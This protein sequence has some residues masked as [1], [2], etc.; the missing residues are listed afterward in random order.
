MKK[1]TKCLETKDATEFNKSKSHKGGL[2]YL[3]K[4]CHSEY[5]KQH[6]L[7]NKD[8]VIEQVK[9]YKLNNPDKYSDKNR[10]NKYSKRAGRINECKCSKCDNIVYQTNTELLSNKKTYCSKECRYKDNKSVYYLYLAEIKKRSIKSGKDF[11]LTEHFI[12]DLLENKQKN[13][14]KITSI[15]IRLFKEKEKKTLHGSASLD[16]IDSSRG[17]TEDN[18]QW[19]CLGIN[20]MKL[21]YSDEDLHLLLG[22][23]KEKYVGI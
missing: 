5:R 9:E 17:Y 13:K 14:C 1:C 21:N 16:R 3:C 19:V 15:D 2:S 8:K 4:S 11:N 18:V 20:Y 12:K 10:M 22:M 7:R 6:Y 23:I